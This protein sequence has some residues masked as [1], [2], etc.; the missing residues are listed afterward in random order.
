MVEPA[1][2]EVAPLVVVLIKVDDVA[3]TVVAELPPLDVVVPPV[4][5]EPPHPAPTTAKTITAARTPTMAITLC[6]ARM[7]LPL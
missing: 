4:A 3:P 1:V 5:L 2:D 7:L 6:V